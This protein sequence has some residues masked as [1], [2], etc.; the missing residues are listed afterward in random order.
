M[1]NRFKHCQYINTVVNEIYTEIKSSWPIP[2]TF[3]QETTRYSQLC[4]CLSSEIG[5]SYTYFTLRR[6]N[7]LPMVMFSK[8]ARKK[9]A[10]SLCSYTQCVSWPYANGLLNGSFNDILNFGFYSEDEVDTLAANGSVPDFGDG[11]DRNVLPDADSIGID[12]NAL[13]AVIMRVMLRWL[14]GADAVSIGVPKSETGH[15]NDYV[16]RAV[17]E[18]YSYFPVGLR[19]EAGFCSYLSPAKLASYPR[20]HMAF[21][22]QSEA[23]ANTVFLDGSSPLAYAR[24][25]KG[26]ML[27][28]LKAFVAHVVNLKDRK[29]RESF[30]AGVFNDL[31]GG[32]Q[33]DHLEQFKK[34]T[35]LTYNKYGRGLKL[36]DSTEIDPVAKLTDWVSYCE[37][38]SEYP[39]TLRG[40]ID[41]MIRKGLSELTAAD[42]SAYLSAACN[43]KETADKA[44]EFRRT[45]NLKTLSPR[46]DELNK[47]RSSLGENFCR[48]RLDKLQGAISG[49]HPSE[50]NYC[51]VISREID[52]AERDCAVFADAEYYEPELDALRKKYYAEY[53]ASVCERLNALKPGDE[54]YVSRFRRG[55]AELRQAAEKFR[56]PDEFAA[57]AA[58]ISRNG[59]EALV[60]E[61][62]KHFGS[63][64]K[65]IPDRCDIKQLDKNTQILQAL[66][67][68]LSGVIVE[69]ESR[70]TLDSEIRKTISDIEHIK[71]SSESRC[72]EELEKQ[73]GKSFFDALKGINSVYDQGFKE[74]EQQ[75]FVN[76]Y[77]TPAY[78][79]ATDVPAS[80]KQLENSFAGAFGTPLTVSA[81]CNT[82]TFCR[83]VLSA[84]VKTLYS[85][86][87]PL[88]SVGGAA[89]NLA[90]VQ[91]IVTKAKQF[92]PEIKDVT[93]DIGAKK[94]T[95]DKLI[96]LFSFDFYAYSSD[97]K[98]LFED[99][100]TLYD[101]KFFVSKDAFAIA[102]EY[103]PIKMNQGL[104]KDV[105]TGRFPGM[106]EELRVRF[107]ETLA[108]L[109]PQKDGMAGA[110]QTLKGPP[111]KRISSNEAK[112]AFARLEEKYPKPAPV[113]NAAYPAPK[114][115]KSPA[116]VIIL[117]V[118]CAALLGG[119]T[120]LYLRLN[121]ANQTIEEHE[122]TI[123]RLE[124]SLNAKQGETGWVSI[125]DSNYKI[126]LFGAYLSD[127]ISELW[128]AMTFLSLADTAATAAGPYSLSDS[129][130]VG[131]QPQEAV[132]S[133]EMEDCLLAMKAIMEKCAS[134]KYEIVSPVYYNGTELSESAG[135]PSGMILCVEQDTA[136]GYTV[137]TAYL[138]DITEGKRE[139]DGFSLEYAPGRSVRNA[140]DYDIVFYSGEW[141]GDVPNGCGV[142]RSYKSESPDAPM[143]VDEHAGMFVEGQFVDPT[144]EPT[145]EPSTTPSAEP[146]NTPL[147]EPTVSPAE[148]T[149]TEDSGLV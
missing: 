22:P 43:G 134:G 57:E 111:E 102:Q 92:A 115:A 63:R 54:N 88:K 4:E 19:A 26:M 130:P 143:T 142:R 11:S 23:N 98:N 91:N 29:E 97:P 48:Q 78:N 31:E 24:I 53:R 109:L 135:F 100:Q 140:A 101:N 125:Y 112:V 96:R 27:P 148:Q 69:T 119:G 70:K 126:D 116:A 87:Q 17:S 127:E 110:V 133:P 30:I 16:L 9:K 14:E 107:L 6:E 13:S 8:S 46:L 137:L 93:F 82:G 149:T 94:F 45:D 50:R 64:D 42:Y 1:D 121:K 28:A 15:Y 66:A 3:A 10:T 81:I 129:T 77:T 38:K 86:S 73:R 60:S 122:S 33:G 108:T 123:S 32:A 144:A 72:L 25:T 117:G 49:K 89:K 56:L 59:E 114:K 68:K 51:E 147:A 141:K 20:I 85:Q 131:T 75:R 35:G 39:E 44:T 7:E 67:E 37:K 41:N 90:N 2:Q 136:T 124:N 79:D 34:V 103:A 61:I 55:V 113:R 52:D 40:S 95:S 128:D 104:M 106:D 5:E 18:I 58:E 118:L 132:F 99:V 83:Q 36:L 76:E 71:N 84:L 138:G 139:G 74:T 47:A 146:T 145:L 12:R 120:F 105:L 62:R 65:W 21:V 80:V